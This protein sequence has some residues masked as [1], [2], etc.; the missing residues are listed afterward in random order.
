MGLAELGLFWHTLPAAHLNSNMRPKMN[1]EER[2][3]SGEKAILRVAYVA[4]MA[5]VGLF[6]GALAW[7]AADSF[8]VGC[9]AGFGVFLL[10]TSK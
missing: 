6:G 9:I 3:N 10:V 2:C 5:I 7:L 1:D 8:W 4:N